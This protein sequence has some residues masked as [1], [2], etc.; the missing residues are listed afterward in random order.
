M[1]L[2]L[3]MCNVGCKKRADEV[4][5]APVAGSTQQWGSQSPAQHGAEC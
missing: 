2:Q 1:P 3:W 5:S 4:G